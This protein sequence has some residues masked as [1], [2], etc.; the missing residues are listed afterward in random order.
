MSKYAQARPA[1]HSVNG[2]FAPCARL[3]FKPD[4]HRCRLSIEDATA[5]ILEETCSE[6]THR[7]PQHQ[8]CH[9]THPQRNLQRDHPP[10][11]HVG[12]PIGNFLGIFLIFGLN[13]G[14]RAQKIIKIGLGININGI[15]ALGIIYF[16]FLDPI[17]GFWAHIWAQGPNIG[18]LFGTMGPWDHGPM[19]PWAQGPG[20][21]GPMAQALWDLW[22]Y[23]GRNS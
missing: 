16:L 12:N 13:F 22:D 23:L 15:W 10:A 5:H 1:C 7:P 17:F 19:G 11:A 4:T 2:K 9:R 8:R 20:P 3:H 18:P 6:T 14:P 21:L